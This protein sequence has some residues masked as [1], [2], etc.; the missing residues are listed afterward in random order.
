MPE[1][2]ELLPDPEAEVR[3]SEMNVVIMGLPGSGKS[4]LM[5]SFQFQR[6][7]YVSLGDI[8]RAELETDSELAQE[9]R[10]K[11]A[12]DSPWDAQFIMRVIEPHLLRARDDGKGFVL[13]GLRRSAEVEEFVH[14]SVK[15]EMPIDLALFLEVSE[16]NALARIQGR[17]DQQLRPEKLAH[18]KARIQ[19]YTEDL[20]RMKE[21]FEVHGGDVLVYGTDY[22]NEAQVARRLHGYIRG[23]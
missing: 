4:T 2:A 3:F 21:L 23:L 6:P 13:D 10:Q 1:R 5:D 12:D 16:E 15:Q 11:F 17:P 22:A 14:W 18:Y 9:I 7:N 19:R 20:P 8:T